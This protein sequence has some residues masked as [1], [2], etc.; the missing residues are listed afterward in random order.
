MH[1]GKGVQGENLYPAFPYPWFRRVSRDDD[2]AIFAYLEDH[3]GGQLHAAEKQLPFPLS[4]RSMV[5]AWNL[6]LP[7]QP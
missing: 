3:A 7:R 2:D 6:L 1:D 4:F 5:G